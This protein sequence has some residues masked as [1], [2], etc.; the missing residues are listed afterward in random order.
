MPVP[1]ISKE[2]LSERLE[3]GG[4]RV[5][6]VVDARLKYPYEHSTVRLPG[7]VR[8][9]PPEFDH[10][11]LPRDREIIIYDSDPEEVVG[12]RIAAALIREGCSASVLEGGIVEWLAAKL[13]TDSKDAPKQK[14]PQAGALKG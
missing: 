11:S 8:L 6:V 9:D 2:A 12:A 13:P 3:A 4:D 5:P 7:A 1:R 10:S 14:P